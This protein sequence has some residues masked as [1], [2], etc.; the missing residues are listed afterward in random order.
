[1]P[2]ALAQRL[3]TAVVVDPVCAVSSAV[4]GAARRGA[5]WAAAGGFPLLPA[6]CN[7]LAAPTGGGAAWREYASGLAAFRAAHGPEFLATTALFAALVIPLGRAVATPLFTR[8]GT[9]ALR[10]ASPSGSV[11]RLK[12]RK[13]CEA[14]WKLCSY[15]A[16]TSAGLAVTL[17][18]P[19]S[20]DTTL[21]WRSW[22]DQAHEPALVT[23][24][25]WQCGH[26]LYS[27]FDLCVWESRRKDHAAMVVHH[28]ATL[29][30]LS[31]SFGFA[32]LRVGALVEVLHDACDVFM[33]AAKLCK[34]AGFE[35]GSTAFF[36]AF[37]SA[38][39]ALR[40][41]YFPLVIIK[42]TS[43]ESTMLFVD[44][45]PSP[46]NVAIWAG[47]NA[48]LLLLQALHIYWFYFIALIAHGA[49]TSGVKDVRSDDE[50]E[51]A[52][53]APGGSGKKGR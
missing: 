50:A 42:S 37:L 43:V 22:P 13:W 53:A 40:M 19:W 38:W 11:S 34:Y 35:A 23:F 27:L 9:R 51:E 16:L 1:M 5:S 12:L 32:F 25:G 6:L 41:A 21:L 14:S 47:F 31:F 17:A 52:G 46:E 7:A 10:R 3:A 4:A 28:A 2:A 33:E 45:G 30:L 44:Y 49:L 39:L 26:Y 29:A 20:A 24:Y 36:V 18:R 8:V 15:A 48:L